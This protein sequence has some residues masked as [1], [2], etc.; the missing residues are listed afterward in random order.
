MINSALYPSLRI[1]SQLRRG[2]LVLLPWLTA[3][4]QLLSK[5]EEHE[6]EDQRKHSKRKSSFSSSSSSTPAK[7]PKTKTATA[8]KPPSTF[9]SAAGVK[10]ISSNGRQKATVVRDWNGKHFQ[11]DGV[12]RLIE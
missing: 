8:A 10:S 3:Q 2:T 12:R 5:T 9:L 6:M 4:G 7:A 11:D 1:K